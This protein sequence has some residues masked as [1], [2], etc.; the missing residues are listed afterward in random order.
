ELSSILDSNIHPRKHYFSNISI[1]RRSLQPSRALVITAARDLLGI[2]V[3]GSQA[4]GPAPVQSVLRVGVPV[5]DD[6]D[7]EVPVLETAEVP[8]PQQSRIR[9]LLAQRLV[10][11]QDVFVG[12][13]LA[14]D[15]HSGPLRAD[16]RDPRPLDLG[17]YLAFVGLRQL[18]QRLGRLLRQCGGA[19]RLLRPRVRPAEGTVIAASASAV[20]LRL[21][22]APTLG[23]W[24]WRGRLRDSTA[25]P[26]TGQESR[27]TPPQTGAHKE[28][29]HNGQH[30][31]RR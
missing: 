5:C 25:T 4:V 2:A 31:E 24:R 26:I 18:L 15:L 9:V 6:S 8:R 29:E 20:V 10:I 16:L 27:D 28:N 7:P 11:G 17:D 12:P 21:I 19:I 1:R 13:D 14:V 23:R 3:V 30:D 22:A